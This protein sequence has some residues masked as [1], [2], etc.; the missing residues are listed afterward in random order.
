MIQKLLLIGA[1]GFM[2]AILRYGA[3]SLGGSLLPKEYP[4]GTLIVNLM[5]SLLIG[6][7]LG[8]SVKYKFMTGGTMFH[9]LFITGFLGAFT[10]FSAFSRD[11]LMLLL[12]KNWVFFAANVGLNVILGL[13]LAG[14][15]FFI[16]QK[17]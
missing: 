13:V 8:V 3:Y 16:V 1:G 15:G 6:L 11:N 7:A 17:V 4:A 14:L 12:D 5:G 2:G 10:T 9:Y